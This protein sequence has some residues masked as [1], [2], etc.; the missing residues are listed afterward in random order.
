MK[1]E[2][3]MVSTLISFKFFSCKTFFP[4]FELLHSGCVLSASLYG[5]LSPDDFTRQW[6]TPRAGKG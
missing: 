3:F 6:G 4:K 5:S 1:T 2:H